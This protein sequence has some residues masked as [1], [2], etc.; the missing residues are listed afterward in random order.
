M[1]SVFA[2]MGSLGVIVGLLCFYQLI[3]GLLHFFVAR[4][5]IETTASV[6]NAH[7]YAKDGDLYLQGHY[8]YQDAKGR[9][10][11]FAFTICSY[12]PGDEQWHKVMQRYRQGA[13]N[14]VRYLPW[15]PTFHEIQPSV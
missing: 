12:W 4:Y 3:V 8:T 14:R 15:L 2:V 1:N 13:Q 9:D 6:I 10:H 7:R 5:G 11:T